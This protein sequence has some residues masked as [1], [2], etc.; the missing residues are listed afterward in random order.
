MEKL[1]GILCFC[2]LISCFAVA[3]RQASC[4]QDWYK[5]RDY[6][7][8]DINNVMQR[9]QFLPKHMGVPHFFRITIP[10]KTTPCI[11]AHWKQTSRQIFLFYFTGIEFV[12]VILQVC[13]VTCPF[14]YLLSRQVTCPRSSTSFLVRFLFPCCIGI[15]QAGHTEASLKGKRV[16]SD[17]K[18]AFYLCPSQFAHSGIRLLG[19]GAL[20]FLCVAASRRCKGWGQGSRNWGELEGMCG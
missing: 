15:H 3:F 9:T 10:K 5:P 17:F 20:S 8:V 13:N 18:T 14:L 16:V 7:G 2:G 19:M 6:L 12:Y 1:F 11:C 4:L